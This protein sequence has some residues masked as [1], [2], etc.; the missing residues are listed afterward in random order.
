MLGTSDIRNTGALW[1]TTV[2]L[3]GTSQFILSL[4]YSAT[5][6]SH[7]WHKRPSSPGFGWLACTLIL[8]GYNDMLVAMCHDAV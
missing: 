6:S 7:I 2:S 1:P 8:Q 4:V 5:H 3:R